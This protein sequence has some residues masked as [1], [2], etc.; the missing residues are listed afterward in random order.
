LDSYS[1]ELKMGTGVFCALAVAPAERS[2]Q[3]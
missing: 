2:R 3:T 1:S